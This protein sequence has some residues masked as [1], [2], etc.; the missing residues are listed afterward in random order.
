MQQ[1]ISLR[2]PLIATAS[3][4]AAPFVGA[5]LQP[6]H[7]ASQQRAASAAE[8]IDPVWPPYP[9][10]KVQKERRGFSPAK[11]NAFRDISSCAHSARAFLHFKQDQ[12]SKLWFAA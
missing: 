1:G 7:K 5:R 10:S 11:N 4:P 3:T 8:G 12:T 6:C 9:T 2:F